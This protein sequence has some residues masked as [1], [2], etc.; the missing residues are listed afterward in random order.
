MLPYIKAC[1][2]KPFLQHI[3][4]DH[5]GMFVDFDTTALFGAPDSRLAL[6]AQHKLLSNNVNI[7]FEA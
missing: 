2:C 7:Y 4:G 5:R 6:L 3:N 1:G